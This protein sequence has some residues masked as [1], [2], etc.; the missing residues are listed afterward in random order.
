MSLSPAMGLFGAY[1]AVLDGQATTNLRAFS[2]TFSAAKERHPTHLGRESIERTTGRPPAMDA[3]V[4]TVYSYSKWSKACG[5][6]PQGLRVTRNEDSG[7][8]HCIAYA[9]FLL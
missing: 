6:I 1:R 8:N 7:F 9:V 5:T 3:M 4:L 2:A